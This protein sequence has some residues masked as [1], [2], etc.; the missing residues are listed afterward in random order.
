MVYD[1]CF[2]NTLIPKKIYAFNLQKSNDYPLF[3]DTYRV[4]LVV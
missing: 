3:L 4:D 1:C 2:Y